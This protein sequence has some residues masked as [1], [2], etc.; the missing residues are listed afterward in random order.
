MYL[1]T[2]LKA[3]VKQCAQQHSRWQIDHICTTDHFALDS[4]KCPTLYDWLDYLCIYSIYYENTIL[5]IHLAQ[6]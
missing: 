1:K 5:I 3:D 4:Q 6:T 2:D